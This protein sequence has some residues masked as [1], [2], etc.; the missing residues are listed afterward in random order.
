MRPE[1][2][3]ALVEGAIPFFF[4]IY[5]TLLA[6]RIVGKKPGESPRYDEYHA[7]H[8]GKL[9]VLGPLVALF[10]VFMAF[11]NIMRAR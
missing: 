4:G 10:G 3:G 11:Q 1:V 9:K 2:V 6:Y 5:A 7:K 8:V